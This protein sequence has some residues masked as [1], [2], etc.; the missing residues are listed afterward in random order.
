MNSM[1]ESVPAVPFAQAER[2]KS[3]DTAGTVA[4]GFWIYLMSDGILFAA[5]FATFTVLSDATAGGPA[6][7]DLFDLPHVLLETL[8]L[9]VSSFACGMATLASGRRS[10]G[11]VLAWLLVTFLLGLVFVGM[12]LTEFHQLVAQGAGP[13]RSAFLSAFFTLVG[14]HGLHVSAGLLWAV[15]LLVQVKQWGL[16]EM[17]R[18]RVMCFSLFWHFLDIIW[19]GV[20]TIA[21]LNESMP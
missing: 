6:G 17:S 16:T 15:V 18:A 20:F 5:L 11:A 21:Y 14:T 1:L 12:E 2:G 7:K 4:L 13:G 19:I 3:H 10:C 9:L 8:S